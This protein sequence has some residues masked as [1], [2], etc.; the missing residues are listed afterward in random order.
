MLGANV[1]APVAARANHTTC[2]R[3]GENYPYGD[4]TGSCPEFS[5][6][7]NLAVGFPY[8]DTPTSVTVRMGQARH[9]SLPLRA[10]IF[11]PRGWRFQVGAV[12][13]A[14]KPDGTTPTTCTDVFGSSATA[15]S[16]LRTKKIEAVSDGVGIKAYLGSGPQPPGTIIGNPTNGF[17]GFGRMVNDQTRRDSMLGFLKWGP[18][19]AD[20]LGVD[21]RATLC[22]AMNNEKDARKD[23]V[24]DVYL[25]H[26]A[27]D[28]VYAWR[29][30]I[31]LG[32]LWDP[33][34]DHFTTTGGVYGNE[35]EP[36]LF[37]FDISHSSQTSGTWQQVNGVGCSD[38]KIPNR[39]SVVWSRAPQQPS[40]TAVRVVLTTCRSGVAANGYSL[41]GCPSEHR[42]SVSKVHPFSV[43]YPP[44]YPPQGF[45]KFTSVGEVR[46]PGAGKTDY[47][48]IA[49]FAYHDGSP[50]VEVKWAEPQDL[51]PGITVS[52]Y[53]L[54]VHKLTTHIDADP[55]VEDAKGNLL[56][57]R[58]PRASLNCAAGTCTASV[59]MSDLPANEFS[60]EAKYNLALATVFDTPA[61]KGYRSDY[62]CDAGPTDDGRGVRCPADRPAW[63]SSGATAERGTS[64]FQVLV[65]EAQWPQ[66]FV[67]QQSGPFQL[68][69]IDPLR[70]AA[71]VFTW[72]ATVTDPNR[73]YAGASSPFVDSELDD[74]TRDMR[75]IVQAQGQGRAE[76]GPGTS[77]RDESN[78]M[79]FP[80]GQ[81]RG[82]VSFGDLRLE[83]EA[84]TWRF[85]GIV[86]FDDLGEPARG[87]FVQYFPGGADLDWVR[88]PPLPDP[89][90]PTGYNPGGWPG[91]GGRSGPRVIMNDFVGDRF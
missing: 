90:N 59:D 26:L 34:S 81:G 68:L 17:Q 43:T 82:I 46:I 67:F 22:L 75:G 86:G 74:L 80:I 79:I 61:A 6:D 55:A 88:F 84:F 20:E 15:V 62:L 33:A 89:S 45:A 3:A 52:G 51:S 49:G 63:L 4:N 35:Q 48:P 16:N 14:Q 29:M 57:Q 37:A 38:T 36:G 42:Y 77:Y 91:P 32:P 5:P 9:E 83:G 72:G 8:V 23:V 27:N 12:R 31:D 2:T 56:Y 10:E 25:D 7:S 19:P 24:R 13:P 65:R 66:R 44:A 1:L 69:L 50:F 73:F 78:L 18:A 47:Q 76:N 70:R 60:Y 11:Y 28:P 41:A 39:C 21:G 71:E 87:L 58:F 40:Q 64:F 30:R 54:A 53:A 85:I